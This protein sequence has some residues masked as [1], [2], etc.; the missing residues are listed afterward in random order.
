MKWNLKKIYNTELG[1]YSPPKIKIPIKKRWMAHTNIK[2]CW[3]T[4]MNLTAYISNCA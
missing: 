4:I 3:F 2:S 1:S